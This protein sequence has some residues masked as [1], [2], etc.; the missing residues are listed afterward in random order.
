MSIDLNDEIVQDFLIEA[1]EILEELN[2]QLV[3][4]EGRPDDGELLNSVFRNFHT[5]KGGAGFLAIDP[6]VGV[7]HIAENVF[8]VLR[9]GQRRVDAALMDVVLEVLDVVNSMFQQIK[10]GQDPDAAPSGLL[11]QLQ[12]LSTPETNDPPGTDSQSEA[13]VEPETGPA[14][15]TDTMAATGSSPESHDTGADGRVTGDEI[16]DDEF[17]ALL[18]QLHGSGNLATTTASNTDETMSGSETGA[19]PGASDESTD[20]PDE[21][22]P[23][24]TLG[25]TTLA[26]SPANES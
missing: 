14:Q 13:P 23:A 19:G 8:D 2:E 9:N 16:S 3:S 1:G 26:Q 10:H 24:D 18:D 20:Q 7:C 15:N 17:E 4:L 6:L 21:L 11:S 22:Q 12:S 5:I 25:V